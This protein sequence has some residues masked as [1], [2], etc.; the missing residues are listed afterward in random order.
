[1]FGDDIIKPIRN[2]K[3]VTNVYSSLDELADAA[4]RRVQADKAAASFVNHGH[5]GGEWKEVL[6]LCRNGWEIELERTIEIAEHAVDMVMAEHNAPTPLMQFDVAGESVDVGR[7]LSGEPEC[8]L[9]FPLQESS[10]V[11]KIVT[12][13][14]SVDCFGGVGAKEMYKR[15]IGIT[16]FA[17]ALTRLGHSVEFWCDVFCNDPCKSWQTGEKL[18][19]YVR[20]LVKGPN[21]TLDPSKLLFAYCHDGV[22]RKLGFAITHAWPRQFQQA[23]HMGGGSYGPVGRAPYDMPEGTI[24]LPSVQPG[25]DLTNPEALITHYLKELGL[26]AE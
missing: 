9:D 11:G 1:M 15:G 5:F 17:M 23:M 24:Y 13:I 26:L 19:G 14:A 12:L 22:L 16:A 20:A 3:Y 4:E 7:Y 21:D 25:V 10:K 2:A 18:G 8:M 6:N